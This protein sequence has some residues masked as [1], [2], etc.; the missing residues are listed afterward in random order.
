M[1][2]VLRVLRL[3]PVNVESDAHLAALGGEIFLLVKPVGPGVS[4]D[5]IVSGDV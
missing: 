3:C 5:L 2:W 1:C 4:Q